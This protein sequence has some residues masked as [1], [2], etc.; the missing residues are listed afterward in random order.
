MQGQIH[1]A[2]ERASRQAITDTDLFI[3]GGGLAGLS[4]AIQVA[5]AG[6]Q[7]CLAEK[8]R[9]PFHRVCGEYISMESWDFLES[10]GLP[11][12]AMQLPRISQLT[13]TAPNG[14]GIDQT[15]PLGGFGISRHTLDLALATIAREAG[16]QVLEDTRVLDIL[17]VAPCAGNMGSR[18][19][20]PGGLRGA[21][22]DIQSSAGA[23]RAKTAVGS[24]GKRSNLDVRWQR[25]F[26]QR[27]AGPLEN[28]IGVK[29]HIDYDFPKDRIALHNFSD[30]YCGI[31]AVEDNRYCLCYLTTANNLRK[32]GGSLK[33]MEAQILCM[34]PHLREIF[35][36]AT[37]LWPEPV[38]I[39]QVSFARKELVRDHILF[40]GDAAGMITPLCGNGMSMALHGS[41]ILAGLLVQLLQG[42]LSQQELETAYTHAWNRQFSMRLRVGRTIQSLFGKPLATN[43]LVR[44]LQPFPSL[45]RGLVSLTHGKPF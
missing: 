29:Y 22:V 34:N 14:T 31:S 33:S 18:G 42:G 2:P 17:Y 37:F 15:L 36:Q 27:K 12:A 11:L 5:R 10:L 30:G 41:K 43:L 24:F 26:V 35:Q 4:L 23:F 32:S 40:C 19:D 38:T 45:V 20:A 3:A 21:S 13:V 9:Y 44:S 7:V 39:S 25:P 28:Y 6:F 1:E 16:V 8:E